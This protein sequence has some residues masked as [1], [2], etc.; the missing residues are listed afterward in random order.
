[1]LITVNE[2]RRKSTHLHIPNGLVLNGLSA[3]FLSAKLKDRDMDI[4][5]KQLRILFRAIK[6]YKSTHPEW[7]LVEIHSHD[8][9]IV[10]IML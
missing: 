6:V 4:S 7:K 8:G 2:G 5:G 3:V 9:E 10:E 1:M